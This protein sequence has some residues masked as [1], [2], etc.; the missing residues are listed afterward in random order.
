[1]TELFGAQRLGP[2]LVIRFGKRTLRH[3]ALEN[4][5]RKVH[6]QIKLDFCIPIHLASINPILRGIRMWRRRIY[7][8]QTGESKFWLGRIDSVPNQ[9]K[10]DSPRLHH[11]DSP[12]P[13][14]IQAHACQ[15]VESE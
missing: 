6:L 3:L 11:D 7:A 12:R 5:P 10:E 2:I 9:T 14:K 8:R 13:A 15:S 4:Y 1:M